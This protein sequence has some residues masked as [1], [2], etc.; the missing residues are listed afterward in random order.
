M[1]LIYPIRKMFIHTESVVHS[2]IRHKTESKVVLL[3]GKK[4]YQCWLKTAFAC[5]LV[6]LELNPDHFQC[7]LQQKIQP[8]SRQMP[9]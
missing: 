1:E 6:M 8:D 7:F 3:V 2:A 4:V 9:L 5:I